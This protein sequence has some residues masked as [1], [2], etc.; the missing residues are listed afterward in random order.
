[1]PKPENVKPYEF[2][3]GQTGN[4]NGR[5][6]K[7]VCDLKRDGYTQGQINDT[8]KAMVKMN[9][10]ELQE[11]YDNP[12]ASVLEKTIANSL[13]KSLSK[14]DLNSIETL[15][16]RTYGMPKQQIIADNDVKVSFTR[17]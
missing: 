3:K 4:P 13:K 15:L 7:F 14:G 9:V 5:P 1:M 10:E 8:I 6:R 12:S 17:D 16:N 2:K 11:V